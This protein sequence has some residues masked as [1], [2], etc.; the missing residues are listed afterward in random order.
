M[1]TRTPCTELGQ[2]PHQQAP[3]PSLNIC[4]SI[5]P[6]ADVTR[7]QQYQTKKAASRRTPPSTQPT[8][9][10]YRRTPTDSANTQD[11]LRNYGV[12]SIAE[13]IGLDRAGLAPHPGNPGEQT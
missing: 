7:G 8:L 6:H 9:P 5:S 4:A 11:F 12:P 10:A 13:G 1:G 3:R 2:T